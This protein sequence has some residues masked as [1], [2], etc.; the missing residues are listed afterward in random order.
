MRDGET[1]RARKENVS[2]NEI[3][4]RTSDGRI[5]S[6]VI[7]SLFIPKAKKNKQRTVAFHP[8]L[9]R[10]LGVHKWL[11]TS[12]PIFPG[13][14]QSTLGQARRR[15]VKRANLGRIRSHDLRHS[16][17]RNYLTSKAGDLTILRQHTGH[18]NLTSL[19]P[20]AHFANEDV[21]ATI[22]N[23]RIR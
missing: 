5:M 21:A 11:G 15:A 9:A 17:I 2:A 7:Y 3:L 23:M 6:R 13:W 20:Y 4:T 18:E 19:E 8:R 12:G 16:M 1:R 14:T 10:I 22:P